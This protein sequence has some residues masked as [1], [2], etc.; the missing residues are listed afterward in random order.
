MSPPLTAIGL[1]TLAV[2]SHTCAVE[3]VSAVVVIVVEVGLWLV[4][5]PTLH[6]LQPL[7][8]VVAELLRLDLPPPL[9]VVLLD[10]QGGMTRADITSGLQADQGH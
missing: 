9:L 3:Q 7:V 1:Q 8:V 4:H 10:Q 5:L 6:H 2:C